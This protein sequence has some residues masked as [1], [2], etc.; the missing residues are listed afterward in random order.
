MI[1]AMTKSP[2]MSKLLEGRP[3]VQGGYLAPF[4]DSTAGSHPLC[5][6]YLG[7]GR[8]DPSLDSRVTQ[9]TL[10][11][12]HQT[13]TGSVEGA[14]GSEVPFFLGGKAKQTGPESS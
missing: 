12:E 1:L 9:V 14:A 3:H 11:L 10:S 8:A 6:C 13:Q 2:E 4:G 5:L 7:E